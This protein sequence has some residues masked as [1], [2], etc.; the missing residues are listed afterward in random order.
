[1]AMVARPREEASGVSEA[2]RRSAIEMERKLAASE[3]RGRQL[4]GAATR[5]GALRASADRE[6]CWC[7]PPDALTHQKESAWVRYYY[8]AGRVV[9]GG[10]GGGGG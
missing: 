7:S 4:E 8:A 2:S 9:G 1:M 10:G 6:V 5:A 3:A